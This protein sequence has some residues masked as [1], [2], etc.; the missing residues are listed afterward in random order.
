M[1]PL[2]VFGAGKIAEVVHYYMKHESDLEVAAFTCDREHLSAN[3]F[4]NLPVVAFEDVVSN[5]P[6]GEYDMFV[7]LGYQ[8]LNK[9]RTERVSQAKAMGYRLAS[10]VH[11]DAGLPVDTEIGENCFIMNGAHVQAKARLGDNIFVWSGALVGHHSVIGDNCWI[12]STA[13]ICG[14]ATVGKN[15]FIAANAT[16]GNDVTV[17]DD[18]FI[19][20]NA[21]VTKDLP[22]AA[23]V[24]EKSSE[25]LRVTSEQF[26]RMTRFH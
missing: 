9:V 4:E 6:P 11:R 7:A 21:L 14:Q 5:Y 23:V 20:S 2:I 26:L 22:D 13:S 10:F 25:T 1:K 24:V 8:D 3:S 18:C 12:T 16:I 17:G 19:G 15:C